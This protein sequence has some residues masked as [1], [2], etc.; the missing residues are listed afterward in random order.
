MTQTSS[1]PTGIERL[2]A[3]RSDEQALAV[4]VRGRE[5]EAVVDTTLYNGPDAT[6]AGQVFAGRVASLAPAT[7]A[8]FSVLPAENA[9]GNFT[10]I[11][12]RVPVRILL[13]G[14]ASALGQLRPGLSVV[15]KVDMRTSGLADRGNVTSAFGSAS[16]D[17][18]NV[19]AASADAPTSGAQTSANTAPVPSS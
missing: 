11:V 18:A 10:K 9:T 16:S 17:G 2:C 5:F 14:N 7:G 15:A 13:E 3:D 1:L 19:D 4:A 6:A 12:Q 8:V